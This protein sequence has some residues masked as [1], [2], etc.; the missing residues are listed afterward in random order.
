MT[1]SELEVEATKWKRNPYGESYYVHDSASECSSKSEADSLFEVIEHVQ[2]KRKFMLHTD[3]QYPERLVVEPML[4]I[5][6]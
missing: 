5:K 6:S 1:D 2:K 4:K 3:V